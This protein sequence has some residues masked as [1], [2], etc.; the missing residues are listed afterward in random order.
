[1][2]VI[3]CGS[4][5]IKDY[6]LVKRVI[7][8]GLRVLEIEVKDVEVVSGTAAGVDRKGEKW[9][10]ENGLKLHKYP[11]DWEKYGNKAGF[12]RNAEMVRI[13]DALIAVWDGESRGTNNCILEARKK[14]IPIYVWNE[15]KKEIVR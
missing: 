11:G 10:E 2:K 6:D 13:A 7:E 8:D 9:A 15:S 4:R 14:R 3:V 5:G 1:M 12:I